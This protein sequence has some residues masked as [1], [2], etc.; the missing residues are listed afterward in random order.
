MNEKEWLAVL[1]A[2]NDAFNIK[3]GNNPMLESS[4]KQ[5]ENEQQAQLAQKAQEQNIARSLQ[6]KQQLEAGGKGKKY[7][8]G[9]SPQGAVNISESEMDPLANFLRVQQANAVA[10]DRQDKQVE[11][12]GKAYVGAKLPELEQFSQQAQTNLTPERL[13]DAYG[14]ILGGAASL[15]GIGRIAQPLQEFLNPE[16]AKT[17][18]TMEQIKS[19]PRHELFGASLT[20]LEKQAV[21]LS[22]GGGLTKR[23]ELVQDAVRVLQRMTESK[24]KAVLGSFPQRAQEEYLKQ[25]GQAPSSAP[26]QASPKMSFEEFKKAKREGRL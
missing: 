20:P 7:N 24:K 22:L 3:P 26:V 18:A 25:S 16:A 19:F 17:R 14:G 11:R 9:L 6:L 2:G 5:K 10:Q 8:I 23:P 4:L 15:P 21:E 1:A 13:E 12:V